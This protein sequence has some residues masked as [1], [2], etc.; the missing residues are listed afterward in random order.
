MSCADDPSCFEIE[1][2]IW[3]DKLAIS[4]SGLSFI[5]L[6]QQ[7]K[8][9]VDPGSKHRIHAEGG[10]HVIQRMRAKLVELDDVHSHPSDLR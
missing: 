10:H 7:L 8:S 5:S 2:E 3:S 4:C 9:F 6:E 1:I